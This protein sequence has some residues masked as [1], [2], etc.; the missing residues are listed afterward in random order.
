MKEFII[1]GIILL[2][3]N[4]NIVQSQ[5]K[6]IPLKEVV[7]AGGCFWCMEHPFEKLVGVKEVY[8]GYIGGAS[9]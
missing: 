4:L 1:I 3:G 7:F 8:S 9:G 5:A 2:V 6:E